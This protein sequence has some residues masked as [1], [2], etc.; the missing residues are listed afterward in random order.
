MHDTNRLDGK[1]AVVTGAVGA[2]GAAAA[3]LL[4]RRGAKIVAVDLPGSDFASL[5]A[6]VGAGFLGLGADVSNEDSVR[7]YVR[8]AVERFGRIDIFFNNAGIEGPVRPIPDYPLDALQKVLAVNVVGVFLGLKHVLPV[9]IAQRS[10]SIINSS[11]VAGLIGAPGTAGYNASKHA[12]LGLT[13]TAALEVADKGVRVNCI[14]PG[15]IH[16][17]MMDS[18][19]RGA[20]LSEIERANALPAKRYGTPEEVAGLVAFLASDD[21]AHINGAFHAIDGGLTAG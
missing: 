17:R 13:R 19:D 20:D 18:I 3:R 2:I 16:G 6:T 11:S 7:D 9:M 1:V 12:V 4:A 21:A 14:N 5:E 15:P 10:G 8:A